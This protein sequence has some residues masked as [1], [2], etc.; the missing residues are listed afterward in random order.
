MADYRLVGRD[1]TTGQQRL[2]DPDAVTSYRQ[3]FTGSDLSILGLLPVPHNLGV[4]P[5]SI[6]VWDNTGEQ[7]EDFDN[8][9]SPDE[10]NI[11]VD[12]SSF[13]PIV[14]VWEIVVGA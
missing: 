6:L 11:I 14:G 3:T 1:R 4:N 13:L 12:F 10:N 8:I 9:Q 7:I 2:V 5:S